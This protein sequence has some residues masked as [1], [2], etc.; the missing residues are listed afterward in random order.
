MEYDE[1][2]CFGKCLTAVFLPCALM[3]GT[4]E[5]YICIYVIN[6]HVACPLTLV[7]HY[8]PRT[9]YVAHTRCLF[10]FLGIFFVW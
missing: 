9:L 6:E 8:W 1:R 5:A 7:Y 10:L 3:R 2:A 4:L